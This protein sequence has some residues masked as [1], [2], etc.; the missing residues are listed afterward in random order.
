MNQAQV[1]GHHPLKRCQIGRVLQ[2][3]DCLRGGA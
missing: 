3:R 1:E 2:A